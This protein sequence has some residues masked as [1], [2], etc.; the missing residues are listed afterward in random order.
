MVLVSQD[1]DSFRLTLNMSL[2]EGHF[3]KSVPEYSRA[4]ILDSNNFPFSPILLV[5][6]GTLPRTIRPI[7]VETGL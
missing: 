7:I 4:K 3:D 5:V 6:T 2:P 1:R